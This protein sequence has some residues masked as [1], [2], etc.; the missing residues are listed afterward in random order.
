LSY[1]L[2]S[3]VLIFA[4]DNFAPFGVA[5]VSFWKMLAPHIDKGTVRVTRMNYRE[6]TEGRDKDDQLAIWLRT[7]KREFACVSPSKEVHDLVTRIG[8][9][10]YANDLFLDRYRRRFSFGADPWLIA[11]AGVDKGIIVTRETSQPL[12]RDPK[13]PDICK[14]FDVKLTTLVELIRVLGA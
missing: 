13:I 10:V 7:R 11:Q 8:D 9:Y 4:K 6:M 1:W 12:S 14:H 3:D 5:Q 2:D